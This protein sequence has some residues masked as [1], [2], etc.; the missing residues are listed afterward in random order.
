MI[1]CLMELNKDEDDEER[2]TE[3]WTNAL[4]RRGLWYVSSMACSLFYAIEDGA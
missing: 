3:G 2:G 4:D 1:L